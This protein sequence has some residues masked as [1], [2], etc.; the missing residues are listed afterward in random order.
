MRWKREPVEHID[1]ETW[2]IL[3][4]QPRYSVSSGG[5][6]AESG[7]LLPTHLKS[8]G[9]IDTSLKIGNVWRHFSVHRLVAECFIGPIPD[10]MQVNHIDG[11]KRNNAVNN[12]EIL[13]PKAN[14]AH[15]YR[16]GLKRMG[17]RHP[18]AKFSDEQIRDIR[19]AATNGEPMASI[20][21]RFGMELS[22]VY[23]VV[24][25]EKRSINV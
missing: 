18:R 20:S 13:T 5:R 6:V 23:D 2:V 8:N 4:R 16:T 3:R 17:E 25:N 11:N 1:G 10:G 9:Y 14:V 12:L 15:A 24:K 22:Y 21:A 19:N 7:E